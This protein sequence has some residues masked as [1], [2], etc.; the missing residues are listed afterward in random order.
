MRVHHLNCGT[1]RPPGIVGGLVCHVLLIETPQGLAL[2]DA[3]FGLADAAD[4]RGRLGSS[5]HLIRPVYDPGEAVIH[6]VRALGFDPH[7]VRHV[8]LTHFDAD[9]AG[10]VADLPWA[11]VH[12]TRAENEAALHPRGMIERSRYLPAVRAHQPRIV[13]HTLDSAE[14]WRGFAGVSELTA[15]APGIMLI[16]LPGH[17]RGHAAVA[18]D[19]GDR[20]VLHVGD[21]FYDH[22][23]LSGGSAP[24]ALTL[25]ERVIAADWATVQANHA[26]LSELWQ[27]GEPDLMLVNA[28]DPWLLDRARDLGVGEARD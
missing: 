8:V 10:G 11:Q 23:Q 22:R 25:M 20:W 13:E 24:R 14:R 12:L 17:T 27:A 21:A 28:H 19:A 26:R 7:D 16:A 3:G 15:I 1:M 4:P 6:Q 9:H 2:V 5:R 18:V